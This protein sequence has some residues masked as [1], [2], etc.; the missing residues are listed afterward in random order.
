MASTNA[1][2]LNRTILQ[3]FTIHSIQKKKEFSFPYPKGQGSTLF[4]ADKCT[5]T[6][7]IFISKQIK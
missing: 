1:H 7:H 4:A 5:Y 6:T 3:E 2:G